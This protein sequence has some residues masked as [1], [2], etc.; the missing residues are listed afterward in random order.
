M[1]SALQRFKYAATGRWAVSIRTYLALVFPFGFLTSIEREQLFHPI[2]VSHAATI[3]LGGELACAL[4]LFVVQEALLGNRRVA[5]QPL[6][7]VIFVWVSAG[8]VRGF[9]TGCNAHWG[10]GY[11]YSFAQRIP[12]AALY[13]AFAMALT[14]YYFGYIDRKR[15]E[16]RALQSLEGVLVQEQ[17]ELSNIQAAKRDEAL[18]VLDN[19]LLPQVNALRT[20]VERLVSSSSENGTLDQELIADLYRQS[21]KLSL[22]LE[23]Q[24]GNYRLGS[25]EFPR[26]ESGS[27]FTYW[28]GL[29]PKV[30][31]IR[32]TFLLM[33]L[34]SFSGQ[35]ARNGIEGA[36]AGLIGAVIVTAYLYPIAQALKKKSQGR[37]YLYIAA[38]LGAF[39][40]QGLYNVIQP[41]IGLNLSYPYQPWYSGLKTAYGVFVGSVIA[42]LI[43]SVEGEF[44]GLRQMG[45]HLQKTVEELGIENQRI[46]ESIAHSRFGTLQG[47]ITGVTMALH[48]MN[49]MGSI[50]Q[51]RRTELLAGANQLLADSLQDL[52]NL[53]VS[54]R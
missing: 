37:I 34:G 50:S 21:R 22:G 1:N 46:Q 49:S 5:L 44:S 2:S 39:L 31:S 14:S 10:Y 17:S 36:F 16:V 19:Q 29:L 38:Y 48:L 30:V 7:R 45:K 33:V 26:V 28:T 53:R 18:A 41:S 47:K 51:E 54:A 40:V 32:I 12:S 23:S 25:P 8:L 42:S 3:A 11:D 43:V 9:F 27:R 15:V 52:E 20:G 13:T 6:S 4:Y 24:V 35:F